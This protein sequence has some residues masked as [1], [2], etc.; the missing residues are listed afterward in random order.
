MKLF[1]FFCFYISALFSHA[2]NADLNPGPDELYRE[3]EVTEIWITISDS[4]NI[5]LH[6]EENRWRN[7]YVPAEI[8]FTNSKLKQVKI[9]NAGLRLRGNTARGHNKRSYKIDFKEFG[10]EKFESYKKINLKPNVN[11]P[12]HIRELI[13]MHMYRLMNVLASRVAP[14]VVYINEEFKGVYL[15]IEQIDDEFIDKRFGTE[16]GFL[17]KCAYS[18]TLEDDGQINDFEL[19]DVKMNEEADTRSELNHFVEILNNSTDEDFK[20][21]IELVFG[22][23][24][25]L[26][27]MAVEAIIG[28]WDGYSY[29][30]N[31]YYL[32][33][34]PS[35]SLFEFI[36]YDTDNTL[37]ID[38]VDRDWGTRD[39]THFYRHNHARPLSSRILEVDE[40]RDRYYY[41]LRH[42]FDTYFTEV[43]LFPKFDFYKEL[44]KPF[45]K[46]DTYFDDSFD[47][48]YSDFLN[49]FE[50]ESNRQAKY[51]LKGFVK[52]R[53]TTG[54]PMVPEVILGQP[55]EN[56]FNVYPNPIKDGY[57]KISGVG[58]NFKS[59]KLM[60]L[61]G[62]EMAFEVNLSSWQLAEIHCY[63]DPGI[64]LLKMDHSSQKIIIK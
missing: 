1:F 62:R 2:Q 63:L 50:Y 53:R 18:A 35:S 49:A 26:R 8:V 33:Y 16:A 10:G 36:A 61:Q 56:I 13:S 11:D 21:E 58:F 14:T 19:Y 4:N 38:W 34:N 17:Y 59:L 25:F 12:A 39:L 43:Y 45:V 23:D 29:L 42:L 46:R 54:I 40:Y 57:F 15:N 44:L 5:L 6:A 37:G 52:T 55:S 64:Y 51:G 22:V 41:Y 7:I 30:N 27:Q 20:T 9:S 60:D 28:H 32:Y 31:N 48:N 3:D 47:F 24:G